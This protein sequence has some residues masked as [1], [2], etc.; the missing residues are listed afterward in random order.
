VIERKDVEYPLW[1]KKV[2]GSFL[3]EGMTPLPVWVR[4]IWDIDL[5]FQSVTSI[6]D[7][8]GCV[9]II[10]ENAI[11]SGH[12]RRTK[13]SKGNPKY[14][15]FIEEELRDLLRSKFTMS[16]F[17]LIETE[18]SEKNHR[19]ID[20]EISFWEFLDIEFDL[21][22]KLF[23]FCAYYSV[24]PKFPL[25]FEKLV[26]S[27]PLKAVSDKSLNNRKVG[28]IFKQSW[29]SK[30]E[31]EFQIGAE[32][33]IYFLLDSKNELLY[34]GEAKNLINR[35]RAGHDVIPNWDYF[36]Y[37]VLPNDLACYR[38]EIE[39]ML[40]KDM[41]ALLENQ[42]DTDQIKISNYKLVNRKIDK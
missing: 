27:A 11:Y 32:N 2:D 5:H 19:E 15:L 31:F 7:Q 6:K 3:K 33:V 18:L 30:S 16:Y 22:K 23:K 35:F 40:I 25:L 28:R 1:R 41:A 21:D 29:K 4:K 36:K 8:D 14:R 37:S 26:S 9:T 10:F 39:R 13:P 12:L 38:L 24:T 20:N 34:V 17:R 42:S